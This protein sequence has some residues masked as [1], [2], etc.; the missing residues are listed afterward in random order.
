[1]ETDKWYIR[2]KKECGEQI[3][4]EFINRGAIT[5][6]DDLYCQLIM[7]NENNLFY[8]TENCLVSQDV[9]SQLGKRIIKNWTEIKIKGTKQKVT[10]KPFDKVLVCDGKGCR[11]LATFFSRFVE[12]DLTN[13][14]FKITNGCRYHF[15]IPYEGNEHLN[16]MEFSFEHIERYEY[17]GEKWLQQQIWLKED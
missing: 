14:R 11:W 8:L 3:R 6:M 12:G 7:G 16:G 13:N 5:D 9:R 10:F 17:D 15:C 2:G 1:M 4:Q